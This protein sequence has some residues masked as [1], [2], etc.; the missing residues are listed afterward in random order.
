MLSIKQI[1]SALLW[2]SLSQELHVVKEEPK[3]EHSGD[4]M[5]FL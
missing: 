3:K 4:N 2:P 5:E 1:L